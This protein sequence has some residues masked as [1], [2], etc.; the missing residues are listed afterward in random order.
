MYR[1]VYHRG[2]HAPG[3]AVI[4]QNLGPVSA[5]LEA[6]RPFLYFTQPAHTSARIQSTLIGAASQPPHALSQDLG[7]PWN[8]RVG[9]R[10]PGSINA[11]A[12]VSHHGVSWVKYGRGN[13]LH[14]PPPRLEGW[15]RISLHS[16]AQLRVSG[17]G[18]RPLEPL[19]VFPAM[20]TEDAWSDN[21]SSSRVSRRRQD[22]VFSA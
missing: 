6:L 5:G 16:L 17:K 7:P 1:Q 8:L 15:L 19:P 2:R 9:C 22:A 20:E 4:D 18:W 21:W 13:F 11:A 3:F 14:C 12:H 10:T